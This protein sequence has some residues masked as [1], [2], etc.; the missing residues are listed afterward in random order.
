MTFNNAKKI[1]LTLF[2][3]LLFVSA[4]PQHETGINNNKAE[5]E[6]W[7][8]DAGFGMFIHWSFDSQLGIVISHSMVGAS[9]DYLNRYINELPK[10]FNPEDYNPRE[11]AVL[12]KL[13]GMKYVVFTTKH[14]SGFC[15]WDTK[16]TDFSIS[17][18]PYQKDIVKEY[19]DA[20]RAE[21]LGVG[22]YFSPEDF[23]FLHKNNE[24]VQ[25]RGIENI[26][27]E[28]KKKYTDYTLAQLREL[29]TNYG[30]ID[31][32]F[33]DGGVEDILEA[34]KEICW[35]LQPDILITRGAIPTP[36]QTLP[37]IPIEGA[38]ES[39]ITMGTQ[40]QYKPTNEN[41]K[42]GKRLIE[43]LIE[44][45]A[46]GGALL[47]NVGPKPNGELPIEQEENLREIA[48]WHFINQE[49]VHDVRPWIVTNEE[50]IWFTKHKE[51][52]VVYAIVTGIT[53]WSRGDRKEFV[54]HSVKATDKT[55][56]SVLGQSDERVEYNPELDAS[57][58]YDQSEDGLHVS[59]VK[60]QRIYNSQTKTDNPLVIKLENV[61]P[62]LTPPSVKTVSSDKNQGS[63]ELHGELLSK[64]DAKTVEV[65]FQYR[66]YAGF[67]FELYNS[68]W[69][70]SQFVSKDKNGSYSIQVKNLETNKT[71]QYRSVVKHPRITMYGDI[72]QF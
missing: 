61:K 1:S 30:K 13:A 10:T 14:H 25:R 34:S 20:V 69:K 56:I 31:V 33:F 2:L 17:S 7:L 5:R 53:E 9:E 63:I 66:E 43:I 44:T 22:F 55:K 67:G 59:V 27:D 21:G 3:F 19:V 46:K 65:G 58:K 71:Y 24:T 32:L 57:S 8:Q 70:T 28:F 52:D 60:A 51:K 11:I 72:K 12:A 38:W 18:T 15:M 49:C 48:A 42:S 41:Y 37:G 64:G 45:R 47:L 40:W 23:Y 6:T 39:C 35:D 36:E 4:F 16:T 54:L 29:M 26:S 50:N 68:E 62:A